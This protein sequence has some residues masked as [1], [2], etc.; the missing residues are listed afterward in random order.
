M[1]SDYVKRRNSLSLYLKV[2]SWMVFYIVSGYFHLRY[3]CLNA[4]KLGELRTD[5]G[6]VF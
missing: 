3:L 1:K 4:P 5:T 2:A 6:R